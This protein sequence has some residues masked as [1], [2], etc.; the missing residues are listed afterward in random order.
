[1][2]CIPNL[3]VV[4]KDLHYSYP[5]ACIK[6]YNLCF[7]ETASRWL[8][9]WKYNDCWVLVFITND[10]KLLAWSG[11][12]L[13]KEHLKILDYFLGAEAF[14]RLINLSALVFV[15]LTVAMSVPQCILLS[16]FLYIFSLSFSLF[17]YSVFTLPPTETK[18]YSLYKSP[19]RPFAGN[20]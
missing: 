10:T 9:L 5:Y 4:L 18:V 6:N 1:M 20:I 7:M 13:L 17:V 2:N 16:I 15:C 8:G 14:N 19:S 3:N 11:D 12:G